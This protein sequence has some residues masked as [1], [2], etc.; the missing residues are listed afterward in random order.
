MQVCTSDVDEN[1]IND[2]FDHMIKT[3]TQGASECSPPLPLTSLVVQVSMFFSAFIS[4]YSCL[5]C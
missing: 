2:E 1:V 5:L 3:L 4:I